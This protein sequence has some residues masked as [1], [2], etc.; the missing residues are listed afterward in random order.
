MILN[1]DKD[2]SFIHADYYDV[3]LFVSHDKCP[4]RYINKTDIVYL[5]LL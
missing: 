2:I 4:A 5:K 1:S 3:A